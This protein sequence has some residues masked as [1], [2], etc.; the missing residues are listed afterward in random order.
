MKTTVNINDLRILVF[1]VQNFSVFEN[2]KFNH[3]LL[4]ERATTLS[5][6]PVDIRVY[7]ID[8]LML[9]AYDIYIKLK[10]ANENIDMLDMFGVANITKADVIAETNEYFEIFQDLIENYKYDNVGICDIQHNIL[11]DKMRSCVEVEDYENAAKYRDIINM[12]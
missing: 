10:K 9:D 5:D 12:L 2:K 8:E 7:R 6:D 4:L 3:T 1:W 11:S